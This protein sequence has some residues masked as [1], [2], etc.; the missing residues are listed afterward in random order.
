MTIHRTAVVH[1]SIQA[2][3]RDV[4]AFLSDMENWKTWGPWIRS[5]ARSS[6]R[7]WTLDTDVGVMQV[8]FVEPNSFGVLDHEVT[9]ASGI[10]VTNGMRVMPNGT[11]SE[12]VMVLFQSPAVSTEDFER[13]IRAVTD[14]LAR[15]KQAVE[16]IVERP[17]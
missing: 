3:P 5:V 4:V 14:D 1:T 7:D 8:H 2:P 9:L 15:L 11:G 16:T 10:T 12:L 13:D 17:R 6:S